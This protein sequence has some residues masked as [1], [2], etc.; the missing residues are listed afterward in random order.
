MPAYI[1]EHC[2]WG[3]MRLLHWAAVVRCSARRACKGVAVSFKLLLIAAARDREDRLAKRTQ[4]TR[5]EVTVRK[6]KSVGDRYWAAGSKIAP[7]NRMMVGSS[8]SSEGSGVPGAG[9][10][11]CA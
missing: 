6:R 9:G 5:R 4:R 8:Q 2:R 1:L 10:T 7:G 3:G 11:V